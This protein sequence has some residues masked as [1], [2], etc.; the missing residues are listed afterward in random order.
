M[1][2]SRH[3]RIPCWNGFPL[4]GGLG[5][6]CR[7]TMEGRSVMGRGDRGAG[8]SGEARV[9]DRR[10]KAGRESMAGWRSLRHLAWVM[11]LYWGAI[12]G[13]RG[14]QIISQLVQNGPEGV[15]TGRPLL[16]LGRSSGVLGA[17]WTERG[18]AQGGISKTM[19]TCVSF[20][21]CVTSCH[22]QSLKQHHL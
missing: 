1:F 6:G 17:P 5:G 16:W 22:K 8:L 19:S 13:S 18:Q 3:H 11:E 21:C 14:G 10:V 4:A 7:G 9:G 15:K 2:E 12:G 20:L